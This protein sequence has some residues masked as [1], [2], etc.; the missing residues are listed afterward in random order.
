MY[1]LI[2]VSIP[3]LSCGGCLLAV[4]PPAGLVV[5]IGLLTT[6][7]VMAYVRMQRLDVPDDMIVPW[8]GRGAWT[9]FAMQIRAA[10]EYPREVG[11][12]VAL[13]FVGFMMMFTN[14]LVPALLGPVLALVGMAATVHPVA[15]GGKQ[16]QVFAQQPAPPAWPGKAERPA[17]PEEPGPAEQLVKPE[18]PPPP[19]AKADPPA[20]PALTGDAQLDQLLADLDS[21][22]PGVISQAANRL[23]KLAPNQH[24]AIVARKLG[25]QVPRA[26]A[27]SKGPLVKAWAVWATVD[28]VP[29]LIQFVDN[30]GDPFLRESVIAALGRLKDARAIPALLRHLRALG[31]REVVINALRQFGSA[32]E[33]DV[34]PLLNEDDPFL[35]EDIIKLLRDI[36]TQQSVPALQPFATGNFPG[37]RPLAQQAI[38]AINARTKQ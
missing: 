13:E 27:F 5:G 24:Q 14:F 2:G 26:D 16:R 18:P 10:C 34:L 17:R 7:L 37:L 6:G 33:K 9:I 38:A 19:P 11:V 30:K 25:E 21:G 31:Q 8:Y 36:G 23:A 28:E 20:G 35:R 15:D 1:I 22:K 4:V 32:A 29:A 3:V 12:W